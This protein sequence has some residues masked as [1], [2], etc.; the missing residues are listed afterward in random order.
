M[1]HIYV[2]RLQTTDY[3]NIKSTENQQHDTGIK[4]WGT[5]FYIF[6][7]FFSDP[8]R[9]YQ[10]VLRFWETPIFLSVNNLQWSYQ[11]QGQE[12]AEKESW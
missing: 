4:S 5:F 2:Y 3:N 11:S 9:P 7:I 8:A 6:T 12:A 1:N 10:S